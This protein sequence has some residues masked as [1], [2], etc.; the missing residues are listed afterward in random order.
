LADLRRAA[1]Y[2]PLRHFIDRVDVINAFQ[3][4]P[5]ALV[6]RVDAQVP[7][8]ALRIRPAAFADLYLGG[9]G[10]GIAQPAFAVAPLLAQV[11]QMRHR[12]PGQALVFWLPVLAILAFQNAPGG[13]AA[14]R[15]VRFIDR[16]QQL[17]IG[18]R[19]ALPETVPPVAPLLDL[20]AVQVTADQSRH[21][22]PAQPGQLLHIAS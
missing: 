2:L 16:R 5:I 21:L 18:P 11:V 8:L 6:H 9:S 19:V 20:A 22:R 4:V 13:W 14:Q 17:D 7:R 12:D 15:L 3:A 1:H 10:L